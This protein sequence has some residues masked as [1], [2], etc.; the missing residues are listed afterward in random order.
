MNNETLRELTNIV[1]RPFFMTMKNTSALRTGIAIGIFTLAGF[2]VFET[3]ACAAEPIRH[4]AL[5][6]ESY[7]KE[8]KENFT[9]VKPQNFVSIDAY[10][11]TVPQHIGMQSLTKLVAYLTK[12]ATNDFEKARVIA[13]WITSNIAY[14]FEAALHEKNRPS[15]SPDSILL[16][17]RALDGGFAA[18]FVKMM[19]AAG[20]EAFPVTGV[21]KGVTF[22]PGDASTLKRHT[23]NAFRTGGKWYLVDLPVY[24]EVETDDSYKLT[25]ADS[26]FCISPEQMK[27]T[28]LPDDKR[29]QLLD[30]PITKEQFLS[31]VQCFGAFYGYAVTALSHRDYAITTKDR[32]LTVT[33]DAPSGLQLGARVYAEQNAKEQKAAV[34]TT[35]EGRKYTVSV[36]FPADGTYKLELTATEFIKER[37][38]SAVVGCSVK[39]VAEY[40][41]NVGEKTPKS[42]A[43]F[44]QQ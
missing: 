9:P 44:G 16:T 6:K 10:A 40:S 11:Q 30:E 13:R 14:D 26:F 24:K 32:T 43:T 2:Q 39:T 8:S 5:F 4:A 34:K 42:M 35:R 17:R 28:N 21:Q 3:S 27:Y 19:L 20:V 12:P 1:L 41:V 23:W 25:Y 38:S 33:F 36:R 22:S 15:D 18:L 37:G 29:W 31:S 7:T